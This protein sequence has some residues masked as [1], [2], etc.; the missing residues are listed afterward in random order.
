MDVYFIQRHSSQFRR[1][2]VIDALQRIR[3][4]LSWPNLRYYQRICLQ[5]LRKTT[6]TLCQDNHCSVRD[7]NRNIWKRHKQH[8]QSR[9][10]RRMVA[11]RVSLAGG[12][13]ASR[14][15]RSHV[16]HVQAYL[17]DESSVVLMN[18]YSFSFSMILLY[19]LC[20]SVYNMVL[21]VRVSCCP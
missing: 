12:Y 13:Y 17:R 19:F 15:R 7:S 4:E 5:G 18:T 14:S 3:R 16:G 21:S 1:H 8:P 20:C 11:I 9:F 6:N 10:L 2:C